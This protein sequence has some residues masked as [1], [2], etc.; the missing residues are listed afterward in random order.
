MH[1]VIK[2]SLE[3][4]LAGTLE[5]ARQRLM[6]AHLDG[7]EACRLEVDGFMSVTGLLSELRPVEVPSPAGFYAR[8][9]ARVEQTRPAPSFA[10]LF[11]LDMAFGRRL[12]FS[13]LMTLAVLG[14]YLAV[15][16]P[17][18]AGGPSPDAIMAVQTLPD[19]DATPAPDGMLVTLTAYER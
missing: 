8:V 7:C 11:S 9:M 18:Y 16:E 2:D 19:F 3:E 17:S 15:H 4:Y 10:S 6:D 12:V 5:P 1:A 13:S 14:C